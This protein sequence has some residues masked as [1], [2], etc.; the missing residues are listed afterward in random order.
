MPLVQQCN[1]INE[2]GIQCGQPKGHSYGH[3]NGLLTTPRDVWHQY[4]GNDVAEPLK[5]VE[6]FG[7]VHTDKSMVQQCLWQGVVGRC[8]YEFGHTLPHKEDI[9]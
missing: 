3:N 9:S 2:R 4:I 6:R 7:N 5:M 1:W 8:I